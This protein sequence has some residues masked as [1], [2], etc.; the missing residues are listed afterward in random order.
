MRK[1]NI[2]LINLTFMHCTS[3]FEKRKQYFLSENYEKE[4]R[5]VPWYYN[6][7]CLT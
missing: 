4:F 5:S 6:V 7:N 2:K 1:N 3:K